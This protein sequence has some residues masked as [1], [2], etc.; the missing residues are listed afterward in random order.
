[1]I[2]ESTIKLKRVSIKTKRKLSKIAIEIWEVSQMVRIK[3][4]RKT[5]T[6]AH[7]PE[8]AIQKRNWVSV[9]KYNCSAWKERKTSVINKISETWLR[10]S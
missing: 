6:I 8:P 10:A 3:L 4:W 7:Y 2:W 1:M 5:I 9:Q